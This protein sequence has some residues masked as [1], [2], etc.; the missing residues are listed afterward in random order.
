M[1]IPITSTTLLITPI[2][3]ITLIT[4]PISCYDY[5]NYSDYSPDYLYD[6]PAYIYAYPK[7]PSYNP[8]Y[9]YDYPDNPKCYPDY[10]N[11]YP[12]Y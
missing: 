8:H 5:P 11:Y 12:Y 1:T 2:I 7:F 4:I 10:P 6:Y 3:L 9:L